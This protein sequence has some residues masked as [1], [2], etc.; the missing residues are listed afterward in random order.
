[1]KI[2]ILSDFHLGYERF[3][4]DAYRQAEE[5]LN[6]AAEMSDMIIIP[7]DIFDSR[8]PKPDV[9]AEA[10]NLFRNL[11]NRKWNSQITNFVGEGNFYTRVPIIAIPGTHERRAQ[12]AADPVDILGLAGL[13]VDISNATAIVEGNGEKIAVRGLGGIADDRFRE[14]V[15]REDPRPTD[16][17]FNIF[18][19]HESLYELLPFNQ[20]FMRI[21]ELPKGFDLYVNGHIHNRVEANVHGKMLLIPGSTVLTQLKAGEQEQKGFFIFD[22]KTSKYEF[23]KISSRRFVLIKIDLNKAG[24]T[25]SVDFIQDRID[26]EI[27]STK[28]VPVIRVVLDGKISKTYNFDI[29]I[30]DIP[31]RYRG[32]AIVELSR[33]GISGESVREAMASDT[34]VFERMSVRDY[35]IGIFLEKIKAAGVNTWGISPVE[36]LDM[37]GSDAPKDKVVRMVLDELVG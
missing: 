17:A 6:R 33:A 28:D 35:G 10:I 26:A 5:A 37:L 15:T 32:R 8:V 30:N 7:G 31:R 9:I 25:N 24:S 12:E 27:K 23:V 29:E 34:I 20:E 16:G 36:L 11:S 2:A 13:V 3:R 14:I 4:E 21:V 19:F 1:M 18:M 22:T